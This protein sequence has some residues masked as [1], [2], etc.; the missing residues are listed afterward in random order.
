MASA[1]GA[2]SLPGST[3]RGSS[4]MRGAATFFGDFDLGDFA[5]AFP[6]SMRKDSELIC[7]PCAS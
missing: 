4:E 3:T 2:F 6:L 5:I 1:A 7:G